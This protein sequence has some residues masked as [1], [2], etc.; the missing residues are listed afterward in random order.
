MELSQLNSLGQP[1]GFPLPDWQPPA[2]PAGEPLEGRFARLVRLDA[3]AHAASLL[4][5]NALEPEGRMWTYLPYGPFD[6]DAAYQAWLQDMG[7]RR[8]PFFYTILEAA[9]GRPLGLASYL[10]M[11]PANG[12]IEVGHLHFSPLLQRSPAAT[13]A[14]FLMMQ[15]AFALGYRRYEWKC[16]SLNAPSRAAALRLGFTFEGLFRQAVVVKGRNRDTAWFSITDQEWPALQ[17]AFLHWLAPA[18]FDAQGVQRE[19]L[20]DL[21]AQAQKTAQS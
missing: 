10:R 18:N 6:S 11:D 9:T 1:V 14:M 8:D 20:S 7:T 4:E 19:R 13:E 17:Q 16:D 5:A 15:Q 3:A 2:L 21:T 12:C